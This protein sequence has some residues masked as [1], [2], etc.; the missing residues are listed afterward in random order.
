VLNPD[1]LRISAPRRKPCY[2]LVRDMLHDGAANLAPDP[3]PASLARYVDSGS[4]A[5]PF[6][7]G[8]CGRSSLRALRSITRVGLKIRLAL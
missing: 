3:I 7:T 6:S 4:N 2:Q 8:H 5:Y 1:F